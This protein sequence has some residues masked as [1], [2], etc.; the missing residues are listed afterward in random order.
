MKSG[1]M[2]EGWYDMIK[3]IREEY[4]DFSNGTGR[5]GCRR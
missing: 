1:W 5:K 3:K 2:F 4:K